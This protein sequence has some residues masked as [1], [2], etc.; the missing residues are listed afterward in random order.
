[1][2]SPQEPP[3]PNS[4]LFP[5]TVSSLA[6]AH[7]PGGGSALPAPGSHWLRHKLCCLLSRNLPSNLSA[8]L[9]EIH[10]CSPCS[11]SENSISGDFTC[12]VTK[13]GE[14]PSICLHERVPERSHPLVHAPGRCRFTSRSPAYLPPVREDFQLNP[15]SFP[16]Y[17][18]AASAA[19]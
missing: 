10:D 7:L 14:I 5:P 13:L 16:A 8:A 19:R 2:A 15:A 1:M 3:P 9:P 17:P 4:P 18:I 12:S 11:H 6:G